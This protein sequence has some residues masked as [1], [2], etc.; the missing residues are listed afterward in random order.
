MRKGIERP[1]AE[2]EKAQ[3]CS[4][5]RAARRTPHPAAEGAVVQA[6]VWK[7]YAVNGAAVARRQVW[8]VPVGA[9]PS[10][11][12]RQQNANVETLAGGCAGGKAKKSH[13]PE[14]R[15]AGQASGV[16]PEGQ[17]APAAPHCFMR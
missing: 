9:A 14:L 12:E 5:E 8:L 13:P 1:G 15:A 7:V 4:R 11:W 6:E 17:T 10:Y 3:L 16:L 2:A